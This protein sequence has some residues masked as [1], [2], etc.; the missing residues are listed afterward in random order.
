MKAWRIRHR[1]YFPIHDFSNQD[2]GFAYL[3]T[4]VDPFTRLSL[5]AGT[6]TA[7]FQIPNN[8]GTDPRRIIRRSRARL[9]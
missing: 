7:S 9:A 8:P 2:K 5:I 4:F 3:S 1:A 6:F